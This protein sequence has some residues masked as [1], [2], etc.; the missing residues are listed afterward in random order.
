[1]VLT[2]NPILER[3]LQVLIELR[4]YKLLEREEVKSGALVTAEDE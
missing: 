1:M 2:L 3:K 4:N